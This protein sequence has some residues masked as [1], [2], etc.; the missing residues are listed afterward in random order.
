MIE[1]FIKE[2]VNN[3]QK[4][5]F[6]LNLLAFCYFDIYLIDKNKGIKRAS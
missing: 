3:F 5:V 2:D 4:V 6:V 1:S